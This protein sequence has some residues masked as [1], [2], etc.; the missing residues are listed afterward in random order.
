MRRES[1]P[2]R[3]RCHGALAGACRPRTLSLAWVKISCEKKKKKKK[4]KSIAKMEDGF[5]L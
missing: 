3:H 2:K 1:L 4:K 5:C